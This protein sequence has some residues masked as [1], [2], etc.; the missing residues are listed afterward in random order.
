MYPIK[1]NPA[2]IKCAE[3]NYKK[4]IESKRARGGRNTRDKSDADCTADAGKC[5]LTEYKDMTD[6]QKTKMRKDI[7]AAT[8]ST[9][10]PPTTSAGTTG[11]AVFFMSSVV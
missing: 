11:P 5:Q 10:P 1:D 2:C 9:A 3:E 6:K 8:A 7:L 4:F